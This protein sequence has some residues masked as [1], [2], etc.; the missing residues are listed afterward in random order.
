MSDEVLIV[1]FYSVIPM[2]SM[3]GNAITGAPVNNSRP[4]I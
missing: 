4:S 1:V 2:R 3:G